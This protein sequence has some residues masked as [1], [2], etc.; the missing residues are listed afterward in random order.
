M[1]KDNDE[2]LAGKFAFTARSSCKP[3]GVP[4]FDVLLGGALFILQSPREVTMIFSGNNEARH[5]RLNASHSANPK[6]SWYG[7]SVG[8]YEG[9]TL[10]VDTIG[11]NDKTF[12]DNYRTPHTEKLHVTERW[13][14][15]EDG[16][17]LEI[18]LTIDD[19]DTFNQPFQELRQ[20]DRVN[21]TLAEDI[22]SENNFN[23][24]GIDYGTPTADQKSGLSARG[25]S[26]SFP[27]YHWM[28]SAQACSDQSAAASSPPAPYVMVAVHGV[29]KTP[30]S[31]TVNWSC[32]YL[33]REFAFLIPSATL[34]CFA[35]RSN[36]SF[37]ASGSKQPISFDHVQSLGVRRAI[38]VD[39]GI[40]P[41]L[42][43]HGIDNQR[44]AFIVAHGVAVPGRGH[45]CRMRLVHAHMADLMIVG[46]KD[47]DLVRLLHQ[48]RWAIRKNERHAFGPTLVARVR[49]AYAVQPEF[50]VLFHDLRRLRLQDRI[51]VIAVKLEDVAGAVRAARPVDQRRG[52]GWQRFEPGKRMQPD[53][54]EIRDGFG[55][56][57]S[58]NRCA[59]GCPKAGVTTAA[60]SVSTKGKFR[61]C[62]SIGSPPLFMTFRWN[63][64]WVYSLGSRKA[65]QSIPPREEKSDV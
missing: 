17:K 36:P 8:H 63:R 56:F 54:R 7:E 29:V 51:G 23:P 49:I 64:K 33:P 41:D 55:A 18:L 22:C 6:P 1:K 35:S 53:A 19:P 50:S 65:K 2:V 59:T 37:A 26:A 62:K 3:G 61:H 43:A 13:R 39:H 31:S 28:F 45:L 58:P 32:R 38:P 60:A 11:L 34:C 9:D 42:H 47:G 15:I 44:V 12:L 46:I 20:Y 25:T 21:R 52:T 27:G 30:L 24:F 16:K 40:P 48:L 4:G 10:V 14:M 5:I 57:A